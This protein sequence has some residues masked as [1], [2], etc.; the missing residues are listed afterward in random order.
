[1]RVALPPSLAAH[2]TAGQSEADYSIPR[3]LTLRDEI[4]RYFRIGQAIF[5]DLFTSPAPST[6]ATVNF[7]EALLRDVFGFS[8]LN[9]VGH[10]D[11]DGRTFPVTLEG[12]TG[13]VPVVVVPPADDLDRPSAHLQG[14]GRRRSAASA[15]QEWLNASEPA[16]WGLC[17]NGNAL[18]LIRDNA[19]LT[20]P[21][22]IE[23]NLRQIFEAESFADFAAL[24]L[25]VHVS[26]FGKVSATPADSA[27]ERWRE[28]GNKEGEAARE[29][30]SIG[31]HYALLS[32][33]NG[34]LA[35]PDNAAL[36]ERLAS[37]QL[38]L[39]DFFGQLLR[40]VYRLI[41]LL[42][43]EDRGLLHAPDVSV[44]LRKL[45]AQGYSLGALRTIVTLCEM[46]RA[47]V[48]TALTVIQWPSNS[49]RWLSG[50]KPSS[51]A[52]PLAFSK[53]I[54]AVAT[55]CSASTILKFCATVSQ[56]QPIN[57]SPETT[58]Q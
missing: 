38:G 33:G 49:P 34:F 11:H 20:R 10:H 12:A 47:I 41:F 24:W 8:D 14:E 56:M 35:H 50:S 51:L 4:A 45:Y 57:R 9:R 46:L 5:Q 32:L 30:L 16:L 22:Y 28:A 29:R 15:L 31:V 37:N 52:N 6:A 55:R 26:R 2:E 44:S 1:M 42:A 48:S 13:R 17:C 53:P 36:R 7:T 25:L 3:G 23:A 54:F 39:P 43:A 21:A 58:R 40:L 19:S 27:L 18:R